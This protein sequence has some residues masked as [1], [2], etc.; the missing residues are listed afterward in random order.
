MA[1]NTELGEAL[2]WDDEVSDEGGFTLL[3]AGTYPFE[4]A[5][6]EKEYFEGSNKM[7]PC[8]RAAVT[9]NVLTDTGWVPLVDR[10]M[11]NT[12]TAWRVARFFESLG[13][14]K[15]PNAEG[16]M[17]MRPHWNEIVGRQGWAKIKV[18]T[19]AKKDGGEGEANDVDT[20]LRP[21][22]WPERPEPAQTSI[23]VHEQPAPAQP[24]HQSWDM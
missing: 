11:L 13:F 5:K 21:A 12:K 19:Y 17:V 24:A 4:V 10:L 16:K 8:P 22:E 14:E 15:E 23:P 1:D 7:A 3:P 18:R 20:Y 9:L 6:V 2:D